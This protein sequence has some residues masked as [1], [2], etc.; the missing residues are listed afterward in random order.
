MMKNVFLRSFLTICLLVSI[1]IAILLSF[2]LSSTKGIDRI[3]VSIKHTNQVIIKSQE[4]MT[5]LYGMLAA[6]RGYLLTRNQ[7]FL[8][9]YNRKKADISSLI[10]TLTELTQDNP[11]Q[12]IRLIELQKYFFEF[13]TALEQRMNSTGKADPDEFLQ[14]TQ[15]LNILMNSIIRMGNEILDQEYKLLDQRAQRVDRL[16][17]QYIIT[18]VVGGIFAGGILLMLN[19]FLLNAQLRRTHAEKSLEETEERMRLAIRGTNDGIYDWDLVN[20]S[21]YVSPRL[22]GIL[23]YTEKEVDNSVEAM[24]ALVHPQDLETLL[25]MVNDHLR[26]MSPEFSHI[27]R[28]LH[29]DGHAIWIHSRG[30]AI[31]N[32][33]GKPVRLV[34]AHRDISSI[35]EYELKLEEA[36]A[37]AEKTSRAQSDFLAHMSHEIRT[38]LTAISGVAEIIQN[39]P[40]S[41][42]EREQ[43][44]IRILGSSA[45]SLKELVNNI[46]DYS[47]IQ[48]SEFLLTEKTFPLGPFLRQIA[49]MMAEQAE[50]KKIDFSYDFSAVE[51]DSFYGD[52]PRLRQIIINLTDNAIKFT[53]KGFVKL[54]AYTVTDKNVK[55]LRIKVEDSGVGLDPENLEFIFERFTQADASDSRK[56][57]GMGLGLPIS[58]KL[59]EFMQGSITAE[60]APGAGSAFTLTLPCRTPAEETGPAPEAVRRSAGSAEPRILLVEDYEGNIVVLSYIL[61]SMGIP[62]DVARTGVEALQ[63]WRNRSYQLILMDIQMPEMDGFTATRTIREIEEETGREHT[64]IIG[65]TAHALVGDREKCIQAGMD[66]YVPK[67]LDETDLK[68]KILAYVS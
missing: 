37:N 41:F 22:L 59:A 36:K 28:M 19:G 12:G 42:S 47:K 30:K 48:S 2:T 4:L 68:T 53:P 56:Y 25:A 29:K 44:L 66:T 39:T 63:H 40:G 62:F 3:G 27:F 26:G 50:A 55:Y 38:P 57:G 67:P 34:G 33:D 7:N 64:P 52:N 13:S 1:F 54:R 16:R 46:L 20:N 51:Q 18:L 60:S 49:D 24:N 15:E 61:E 31:F 65:M 21:I 45:A 17:E 32:Q 5:S 43:A 8:N 10:G 35:K 6:Q 9:T 11:A 58:Q 23:G 14:K